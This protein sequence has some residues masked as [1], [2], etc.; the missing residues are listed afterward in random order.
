M[1]YPRKSKIVTLYLVLAKT[2][3]TVIGL[4]EVGVV[5]S[6]DMGTVILITMVMAISTLVYMHLTMVMAMVPT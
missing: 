2:N 5:D 4:T 6:P 1:I 3:V